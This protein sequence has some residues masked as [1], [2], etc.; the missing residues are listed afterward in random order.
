MKKTQNGITLVA[1]IVTIIVLL[2]L[3]GISLNLIA[4]S[5]GIM[6]RA[7]KA[8]DT[9]DYAKL[10]ES[11][12]LS[13]AEMLLDCLGG[14]DFQTD[15][16]DYIVQRCNEGTDK[17]AQTSNGKYWIDSDG[18]LCYTDAD[19]NG[20][21]KLRKDAKGNPKIM[22]PNEKIETYR[23]QYNANGGTGAPTDTSE[24]E[25]G[26][27]VKVSSTVPTKEKYTFLGWAKSASATT[28]EYTSGSNFTMG[29]Q[30]VTLYAVWT[31]IS[32][33]GTSIMKGAWYGDTVNYSANG[34]D[35]WKV[36]SNDEGYIYLIAGDCVKGSTLNISGTIQIN[37]NW[38]YTTDAVNTTL[39]NWMLDTNNWSN[40]MDT[41]YVDQ[42]TGGPTLAQLAI[43]SN[44]KLGTNYNANLIQNQIL[45][46][47][48]YKGS[49][50]CWLANSVSDYSNRAW[51]L[52]HTNGCVQGDAWVQYTE[53]CGI[54]PLV[55]L[56]SN[57]KMTW[58]GTTWDL[59]V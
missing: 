23:V 50:L 38:V 56:K 54:R 57:V 3:A 17:T 35:N 15:L 24:Y 11:L 12:E 47:A 43:S 13:N 14:G 22:D 27:S 28:P 40:F 32:G 16:Y 4:G 1:L 49:I 59:S 9:Y 37:G 41:V 21:V 45:D 46:D 2:I 5:N 39:V 53:N 52:R 26:E 55:R 44:G 58:N 8:V 51:Y 25:E 19:T 42:A 7:T 18:R 29:T 34:C 31:G 48:L 33:V 6:E 20:T 30:N 36:F 10:K